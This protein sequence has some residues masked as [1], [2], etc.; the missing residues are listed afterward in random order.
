LEQERAAA[1]QEVAKAAD[2]A[3]AAREGADKNR[4]ASER[5]VNDAASAAKLVEQRRYATCVVTDA[6]ADCIMCT[7]EYH[8]GSLV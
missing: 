1:E 5:A 7:V 2:A 4:A 6:L 3:K 8:V